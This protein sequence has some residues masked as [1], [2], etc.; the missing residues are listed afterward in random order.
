M[1]E[2]TDDTSAPGSAKPTQG[3]QRTRV[4]WDDVVS[5][6]S[7]AL[8]WFQERGI[9]PTLRTMFYRLVSLGV[10]PNTEQAYKTLSKVT[11]KA[12]KNRRLP[13]DAF[14]DKNREIL[15][16]VRQYTSPEDFVERLV[17][18]LRYASSN[19]YVPRWHKQ[20][21]YVEVWIEKQALADT[22][23]SFL[24]EKEVRI[25]VNR[26]YSGYSFLHQNC[27]R[28]SRMM[29]DGKQ[30]KVLYYGDFD[31][32]GEDM[33]HYLQETFRDEGIY[34]RQD[35]FEFRRI[36]VTENQIRQY[37]L[38]TRPDAETYQKLSRDPR[39]HR[40]VQK[41]G[42]LYA[43]ELDA[44]LAYQPDEFR[45]IVTESVDQY[46]DRSIFDEVWSEHS[47]EAI[48]RLVSEKVTFVED[49]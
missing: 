7:F 13:R 29:S 37:N 31:P 6:T 47:P 22:F 14:E 48:K 42:Q 28:I 41:H 33:D 11:V 25:I 43:V 23:Y 15:S 16:N 12:R 35:R 34:Y 27:N 17:N 30:V 5:Q 38:P 20:P 39:K 45:R 21:C 44:L 24:E 36:A 46:F 2:V 49:E 18:Q 4:N 10:I 26:G 32:S 8:S 9:R 19:Y 3:Y 40:F 1:A